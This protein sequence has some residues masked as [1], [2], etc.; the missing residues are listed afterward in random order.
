[1]FYILSPLGYP[2]RALAIN[3]FS[4]DK[5]SE[6]NYQGSGLTEARRPRAHL[7]TSR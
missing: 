7:H 5:Y 4:A 1:M 6:A 2:F 3:E